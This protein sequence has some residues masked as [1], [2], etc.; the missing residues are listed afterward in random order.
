MPLMALVPQMHSGVAAPTAV[1]MALVL[2]TTGWLLYNRVSSSLLT[3]LDNQ[4]EVRA[5][6][7]TDVVKD[8]EDSLEQSGASKVE[9]GESYAQLVD[10]RGNVVDA[11]QWL[12]RRPVLTPA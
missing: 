12:A 4:L 5:H 6:D 2:V 7:L 11:S 3:E 8:P 1:A 9:L 10:T